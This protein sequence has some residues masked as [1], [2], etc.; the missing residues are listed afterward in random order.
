MI[1]SAPSSA[2]FHSPSSLPSLIICFWQA[3]QCPPSCLSAF[4]KAS[5]AHSVLCS[6]NDLRAFS[7]VLRAFSSV[8]KPVFSCANKGATTNTMARLKRAYRTAA[9]LTNNRCCAR[10][11]GNRRYLSKV[12]SCMVLTCSRDYR[13][14]NV[15][16]T[17]LKVGNARSL[18]V[19]GMRRK[20]KGVR[21]GGHP[22]NWTSSGYWQVRRLALR[23]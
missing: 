6:C 17:F 21:N 3:K 22:Y 4:L 15:W 11:R 16:Q 2:V 10:A 13:H 18:A 14:L 19:L 9:L 8:G 7:Y 5:R 1:S 23:A 20:R 12:T